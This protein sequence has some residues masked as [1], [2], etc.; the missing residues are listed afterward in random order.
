MASSKAHQVIKQEIIG[1]TAIGIGITGLLLG[2]S[3]IGRTTRTDSQAAPKITQRQS[4]PNDVRSQQI[5]LE[6]GWNSISL[7]I[8][9]NLTAKQVCQKN[10]D[11]LN[12]A[13]FQNQQWH[14]YN[15]EE[16]DL[17]QNFPLIVNRGYL[18][19]TTQETSLI[20]KGEYT[21]I[22]YDI[23]EGFSFVGIHNDLDIDV[24]THHICGPYAN[25]NMYVTQV[26]RWQNGDWDSRI[27]N[28]TENNFAILPG[29]AYLIKLSKDPQAQEAT[30]PPSIR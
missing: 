7:Y 30:Q 26:S 12:I 22:N 5:Q 17:R 27:C 16:N 3:I 15:C 18:V 20:L 25:T 1:L 29:K 6:P 24:F 11:I 23:T 2:I 9:T 4:N 8:K 28:S 21:P 10:N 14:I 13:E 19:Q